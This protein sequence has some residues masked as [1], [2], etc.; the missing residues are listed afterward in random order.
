MTPELIRLFE[1]R[2]GYSWEKLN[3]RGGIHADMQVSLSP[4]EFA[5]FALAGGQK[6]PKGWEKMMDTG[7]NVRESPITGASHFIDQHEMKV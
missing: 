1:E 6:A 5:L 2:T 7:F 3:E 4:A